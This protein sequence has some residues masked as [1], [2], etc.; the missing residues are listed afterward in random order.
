MLVPFLL[1][2]LQHLFPQISYSFIG[3]SEWSE[4]YVAVFKGGDITPPP[5]S[6][7]LEAGHEDG[8]PVDQLE[9]IVLFLWE[10][11]VVLAKGNDWDTAS[12]FLDLSLQWEDEANITA[13]IFYTYN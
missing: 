1:A 12:S 7:Q 13:T 6:F 2:D 10:L 8:E 3:G 4:N 9:F 11:N 5:N